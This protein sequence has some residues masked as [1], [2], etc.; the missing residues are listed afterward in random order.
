MLLILGSNLNIKS[1]LI[2]IIASKIKLK[3]KKLENNTIK[4][5]NII[6]TD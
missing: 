5:T 6:R 2:D 4:N 3:Y 1:T